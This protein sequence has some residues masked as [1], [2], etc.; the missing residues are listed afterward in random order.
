MSKRWH[1]LLRVH[2]RDLHI[3][4]LSLSFGGVPIYK[5]CDLDIY[6]VREKGADTPRHVILKMTPPGCMDNYLYRAGDSPDER[7]VVMM[8]IEYRQRAF[9]YL[10]E[11]EAATLSH[12][13]KGKEAASFLIEH[14]ENGRVSL[15]EVTA[16]QFFELNVDPAS[17]EPGDIIYS[18]DKEF[19]LDPVRNK[20]EK[21][22]FA[23]QKTTFSSFLKLPPH[24]KEQVSELDLSNASTSG[25]TDMSSLFMCCDK[26]QKLELSSFDT[27][28]VRSM[29]NMFR[30]CTRL[31]ELNLSSFNTSV[32]ISTAWM[33][34]GCESL[35]RLDLSNFDFGRML[36]MQ[37]MFNGCSSL[38]E[39]ILPESILGYRWQCLTGRTTWKYGNSWSDVH[40]P[41]QADFAGTLERVQ[42]QEKAWICFADA[43][44]AQRRL[45]LGLSER[46]KISILPKM[47]TANTNGLCLRSIKDFRELHQNER[48]KFAAVMDF[49][50]MDTSGATDMSHLFKEC[51]WR[52][53]VREH[54]DLSS[55]DTSQVVTMEKMFEGCTDLKSV[56]LSSFDTSKVK[57]M[58]YM[59]WNCVS[60]TKV[61]LSSFDFS[62]KPKIDSMF[63]GCREMKE[64][65]LSDTVMQMECK[66][67]RVVKKPHPYA[68]Y[69]GETIIDENGRRCIPGEGNTPSQAY[70]NRIPLDD[71]K[72]LF[73]EELVYETLPFSKMSRAQ[74]LDLLGLYSNV[75]L[76]IVPH[77][78]PKTAHASTAPEGV[79]KAQMTET[80]VSAVRQ[81]ETAE[82]EETPVQ[83]PAQKRKGL[84]DFLKKQKG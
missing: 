63:T 27:S 16:Q 14:R 48:V 36:N 77:R 9:N 65:I 64:V 7:I 75:K 83:Q 69:S 30:G 72:N 37:D 19:F 82:A 28:R 42:V 53:N 8:M 5:N 21:P 18:F 34:D 13:A 33:F 31:S 23:L 62:Q 25:M 46:V 10:R 50:H 57:N 22:S 66:V 15:R 3:D 29:C 1:G 80:A 55:F 11:M 52:G 4:K 79:Q 17:D 43:S 74:C 20:I 24:L 40:T 47:P 59:F 44:D 12:M 84:F 71:V 73:V 26:L 38:R 35:V 2:G 45:H 81:P 61:D 68:N 56:D 6:S 67:S 60:L 70:Y 58:S 54:L 51:F 49:S 32:C 41:S 39:L 78:A 76:T